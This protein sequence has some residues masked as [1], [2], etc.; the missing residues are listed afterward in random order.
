[1]IMLQENIKKV[2]NTTLKSQELKSIKNHPAQPKKVVLSVS[3]IKEKKGVFGAKNIIVMKID[4]GFATLS[5]RRRGGCIVL[6][7]G[8]MKMNATYVIQILRLINSATKSLLRGNHEAHNV[9]YTDDKNFFYVP[10]D[11]LLRGHDVWMGRKK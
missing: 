7:M 5:L 3:Q 8:Y 4:V 1:M 6:N 2:R 10:Y 11:E 9:S